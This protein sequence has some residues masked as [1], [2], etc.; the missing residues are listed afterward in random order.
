MGPIFGT[1]DICIA[2]NSNTEFESYSA[3]GF[4]YEH[5]QYWTRSTEAG[6]FLGGLEAFLLE[7]IE[8]YEKV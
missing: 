7:E 6:C 1:F 4:I 3:L 5:P 2:G 8:V